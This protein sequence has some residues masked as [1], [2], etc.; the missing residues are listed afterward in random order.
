MPDRDRLAREAQQRRWCVDLRREAELPDWAFG[1]LVDLDASARDQ[2]VVGVKE[3][4]RRLDRRREARIVEAEEDAR[5]VG[6]GVA[7]GLAQAG[8]DL[9][10]G[11]AVRPRCLDA[12]WLRGLAFGS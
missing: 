1:R 4:L 10:E 7:R 2:G 12:P 5:L 6:I 8:R 3:A 9:A 11:S